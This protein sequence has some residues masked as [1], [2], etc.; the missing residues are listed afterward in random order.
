[1]KGT[2]ASIKVILVDDHP[3][4]REGIRNLLEQSPDISIVGEA[5]DG[6]EVLHL[7]EEL[8]PDVLLLDMEMPGMG[9]TDVAQKVRESGLPVHTLFWEF[10][11]LFVRH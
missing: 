10:S 11:P 2:M 9:G 5:S 6:K 7:V 8:N 4:V 1:M 3:V